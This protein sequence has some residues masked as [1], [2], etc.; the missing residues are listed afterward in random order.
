MIDMIYLTSMI[1]VGKKTLQKKQKNTNQNN[2]NDTNKTHR[3]V[4]ARSRR[5]TVGHA[6]IEHEGKI[7]IK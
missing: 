4:E 1:H 6:L 3:R 7:P 5:M 2:K